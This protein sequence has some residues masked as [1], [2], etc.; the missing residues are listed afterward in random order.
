[1]RARWRGAGSDGGALRFAACHR[2]ARTVGGA[3]GRARS[4]GVPAGVRPDLAS[5]TGARCRRSCHAHVCRRCR[6]RRAAP[7]TRREAVRQYDLRGLAKAERGRRALHDLPIDPDVETAPRVTAARPVQPG[8]LRPD[9]LTR[10]R[11]IDAPLADALARMGVTTYAEIAGWKPADVK[12]MRRALG[13]GRRLS[14]DQWIEQAAILATG[15]GTAFAP[16]PSPEPA[17]SP[18]SVPAETRAQ[19]QSLPV[20]EKAAAPVAQASSSA[21]A[22]PEPAAGPSPSATATRLQ[23]AVAAAA[24]ATS[25][26]AAAAK[27]TAAAAAKSTAAA[28]NQPM[29]RPAASPRPP[30]PPPRRNPTRRVVIARKTLTNRSQRLRPTRRRSRRPRWVP[31]HPPAPS[32]TMRPGFRH[33]VPLCS[34]AR[35]SPA[36]AGRCSPPSRPPRRPPPAPS[37]LRG[38]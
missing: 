34:R 6:D 1:M 9:D 16:A 2:K 22:G 33:P 35:R 17:P 31:P 4:A 18:A 8:M 15:R 20:S 38:A 24:A 25:T 30:P 3:G 26:A 7:G 13:V 32:T 23:S 12:R 37:G 5:A 29:P 10:I 36:S 14:R 11:G 19:S 21:P 27:S 28:E